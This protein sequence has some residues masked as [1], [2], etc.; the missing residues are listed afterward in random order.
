MSLFHGTSGTF[1]SLL[2]YILYTKGLFSNMLQALE[3]I[4]TVAVNSNRENASATFVDIVKE[5]KIIIQGH[6]TF[7]QAILL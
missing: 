4:I 7:Q 5:L 6:R 1:K 2:E 3:K